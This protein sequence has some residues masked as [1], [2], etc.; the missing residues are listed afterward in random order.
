[1]IA[2]TLL[3]AV[4]L[5]VTSYQTVVDALENRAAIDDTATWLTD[6]SYSVASVAVYDDQVVITVEGDGSLRPLRVLANQLAQTLERPISVNWRIVPS[7]IEASD[8][9]AP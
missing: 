2:A 7:Q 5:S 4:P 8:G 6:T 9:N 3:V 1:M